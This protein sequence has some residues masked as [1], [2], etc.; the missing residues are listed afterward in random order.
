MPVIRAVLAGE[1]GMELWG[2]A[3]GT[4]SGLQPM[5]ALTLQNGHRPAA[6]Q[7]RSGWITWSQQEAKP[8]ILWCRRGSEAWLWARASGRLVGGRAAPY[9]WSLEVLAASQAFRLARP[10]K[11]LPEFC[12][13]CT[14]SQ[15]HQQ[16][17][18]QGQGAGRAGNHG[19][20]V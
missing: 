20:K 13:D 14:E 18:D 6:A 8:V 15:N 3:K 12:T 19:V 16:S 17:K 9:A 1:G 10:W 5:R 11:A 4:D 7:Q 2:E